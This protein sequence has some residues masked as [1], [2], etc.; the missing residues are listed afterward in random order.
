MNYTVTDVQWHRNGVSGVGFYVG[1]VD[2][3]E[4]GK[5]VVVRFPGRD[6]RTAVLNVQMLAEGSVKF[7]HNSWRGDHYDSAMLEA[8]RKYAIEMERRFYPGKTEAELEAYADTYMDEFY[9]AT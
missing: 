2:D 1:F 6:I 7:G 3:P 9:N 4:N 5:M 8:I